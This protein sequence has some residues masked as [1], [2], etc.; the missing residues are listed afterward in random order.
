[1]TITKSGPFNMAPGDSVAIAL[2][3]AIGSNTSDLFENAL[4]ARGQYNLAT[5]ITDEGEGNLPGG[6]ALYQNYPN[7]FNP[8][9]TISFVLD[10]KQE[11]ELAIYNL[12]GQKVKTLYSGLVSAG[13]HRMEWD[14][15]DEAGHKVSSGIYFYRLIAEAQVASRKM[16]LLK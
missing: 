12:L 9:T 10:K 7:P 15:S 4:R 3:I 8:S 14:A 1:M 16:T 6:F 5:D 2:A 13:T 11:I